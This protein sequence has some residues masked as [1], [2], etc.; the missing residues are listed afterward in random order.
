MPRKWESSRSTTRHI[1]AIDHQVGHVNLMRHQR[2]DLPPSKSKWKQ[3]SHKQRSKSQKRYS[4][5]HK[6]QRP[7]FKNLIQAQPHKRRDRCSKCGDPKHVEDFKCPARK[8]QCKTCN[9]YVHFP[10]LC[11]KKQ[12]SFK[13][14]NPKAYQLQAGVV[15][16]QEDSICSQPSDLTSSN[17]SL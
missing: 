13:S 10:N 14:R 3:H 12:S 2:T 5:E 1:K 6:N 4:N 7:P 8:C 16:V 15:Y 17:E 11:Y 9:K